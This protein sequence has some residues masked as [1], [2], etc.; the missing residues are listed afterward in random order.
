MTNRILGCPAQAEQGLALT[1]SE[2]DDLLTDIR[3]RL[4]ALVAAEQAA[5]AHLSRAVDGA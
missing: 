3:T 4:L 1:P 5:A 2:I